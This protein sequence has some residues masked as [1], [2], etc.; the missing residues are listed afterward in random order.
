MKIMTIGIDLAKNVFAVHGIDEQGKAVLVRPRVRREQLLELVASL[1]PCVIGMEAC[2]G[3]PHWARAFGALGHTP[4]LMAPKFVAPYR[5]A[6]R[7]GKNDAADAAAICEAVQRPSMRFV[8]LS[9]MSKVG[10]ARGVPDQQ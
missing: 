9:L 1:T 8:R 6:G 4:K 5:M 7:R 10:P 3:A 2:S